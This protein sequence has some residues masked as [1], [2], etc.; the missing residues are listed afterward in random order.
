MGMMIRRRKRIMAEKAAAEEP[1][2][3][4]E[5][6]AADTRPLTEETNYTKTDI[7]RMSKVDLVALANKSG[8]EGA[9]NMS[10]NAI[11]SALMEK[12]GL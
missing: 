9:E 12:F 11:K 5:A 6:S 10:G 8:V 2:T 4:S 3:L 7:A 1:K